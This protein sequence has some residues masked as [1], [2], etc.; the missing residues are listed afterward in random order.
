MGEDRRNLP[1]PTDIEQA[2]AWMEQ[3][4]AAAVALTEQRHHELRRLTPVQALAASD[5]LLSLADARSLPEARIS[6]SGLV[7]QQAAFRLRSR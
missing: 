2:R 7:Q 4:R 6:S 5:A 3:W 1:M